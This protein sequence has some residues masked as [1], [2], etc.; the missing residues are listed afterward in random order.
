M[1]KQTERAR[2]CGLWRYEMYLLHRANKDDIPH[3]H[4]H[5]PSERTSESSGNDNCT[6][7]KRKKRNV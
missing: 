3:I 5:L 1:Y 2:I 7:P 4:T 6:D